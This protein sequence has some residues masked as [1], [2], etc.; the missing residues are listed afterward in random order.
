MTIYKGQEINKSVIDN[1]NFENLDDGDSVSLGDNSNI[2]QDKILHVVVTHPNNH[3]VELK[4]PVTFKE[5]TSLKNDKITVYSDVDI[6]KIDYKEYFNNFD[7]E[8]DKV[9]VSDKNYNDADKSYTINLKVTHS[10]NLEKII[11]FKVVVKPQTAVQKQNGKDV[12]IIVHIGDIVSDI[13]Y[14]DYLDNFT[15]EDK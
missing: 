15:D 4:I 3:T 13:F 11:P 9:S 8:N 14:T 10:N 6:S 2:N 5:E 7:E 12:P 1:K